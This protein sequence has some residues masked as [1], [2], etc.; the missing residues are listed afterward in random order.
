MV[1]LFKFSFFTLDLNAKLEISKGVVTISNLR[2]F[3]DSKLVLS[4]GS[5]SIFQPVKPLINSSN[6][7]LII[8]YQK[9]PF[10]IALSM[11][12]KYQS[13]TAYVA[14]HVSDCISKQVLVPLVSAPNYF[15]CS[16]S[17]I[18]SSFEKKFIYL[19]SI[20]GII[21]SLCCFVCTA[22]NFNVQTYFFIFFIFCSI[23]R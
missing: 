14:L 15:Y 6:P 22:Y 1:I 21:F 5:Q 7:L 3:V 12:F 4:T 13:N 23:K 20:F 19:L 16:N 8:S 18:W 9:S 17:N 11:N 10:V 2:F